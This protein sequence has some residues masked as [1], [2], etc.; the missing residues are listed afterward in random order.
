MADLILIQGPL[1]GADIAHIRAEI[2]AGRVFVADRLLYE[3]ERLR[4][5]NERLRAE[6][7][8]LLRAAQAVV[9]AYTAETEDWNDG[10]FSLWRKDA[11]IVAIVSLRA[12][13]AR[14]EPS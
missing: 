9:T 8:R 14:E 4:I 7:E 3:I 5:E 11:L 1:T 2:G 13:L 10:E 6:N 12:A